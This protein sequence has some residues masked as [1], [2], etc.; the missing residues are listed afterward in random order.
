MWIKVIDKF[1][2]MMLAIETGKHRNLDE[3]KKEAEIE[4]RIRKKTEAEAKHQH[5]HQQHNV[6][7]TPILHQQSNDYGEFSHMFG[8]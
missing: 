2:K 8:Y 4:A 3:L 7:S 6:S 1:N 5:Q